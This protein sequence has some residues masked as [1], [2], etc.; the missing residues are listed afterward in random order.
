MTQTMNA[1][2]QY[3]NEA[4]ISITNSIPQSL[5]NLLERRYL[6]SFNEKDWNF[7]IES[8]YSDSVYLREVKEIS[9][10]HFPEDMFK[11]VPFIHTSCH[12]PGYT[13][14]SIIN[15]DGQKN[16]IFLGGKRNREYK[17][18]RSI[19]DYMNNIYSSNKSF[20]GGLILGESFALSSEKNALLRN[21]INDSKSCAI[22]TGIPS[23]RNGVFSLNNQGLDRLCKSVS[24]K[25]T[26]MIVAKAI[27]PMEL[28]ELLDS[29]IKLKSEIHSLIIT[30]K[31]IGKS[32]SKTNGINFKDKNN[33]GPATS[34][35]LMG[36]SLF[37]QTL[38]LI[39]GFPNITDLISIAHNGGMHMLYA[40][41]GNESPT[42][43]QSETESTSESYN[44][45]ILDAHAQEV[46][47]LLN[48]YIIRLQQA[49]GIG[50]WN[51]AVYVSAENSEVLNLVIGGL[52]SICSGDKTHLDP[53]REIRLDPAHIKSAMLSGEL[54]KLEPKEFKNIQHPFGKIFNY[55]STC[56][57]S[58][59]LSILA[60]L[61]IKEIVGVPMKRF[62]KF[63]L[64]VPKNDEESI[65]IGN[66]C[67][68]FDNELS[69]IRI[70]LK[71]LNLHT[72]VAGMPGFGKTTT[73]MQIITEAYINHN[74][75][76][77]VIE[78][79][80]KEYRQLVQL[81]KLKGTLKVFSIE[82]N[83]PT[84]FRLNP[85]EFQEGV[86]ISRH[87][88]LLKAVFNASFPMFAGMT[89]VL[90]EALLAV[91][92]E[93]GWNIFTSENLYIQ[94]SDTETRYALMPT[95]ED[96]Y[97]KIEGVMVEKKYGKEIHQ[98]LEA[99]LKS[100]IKS[101]TVGTK[102][103]VLNTNRSIP[104]EDLMNSPSIIE[105]QDLGDDQEKAFVMALILINLYEYA[106]IRQD[107][108]PT[109]KREKLQHLTLIE[110]AHRLLSGKGVAV[111]DEVGDPRSK[112]VSMFTDMLAEVRAYGEGL[113]IADQ[114]PTKLAPEI[115][116]N[117]NLKIMH[118]LSAH[119]DRKLVGQALNLTESQTDYLNNLPTFYAIIHDSNINEAVLSKVFSFKERKLLQ[120]TSEQEVQLLWEVAQGNDTTYL[121]RH[122]GCDKCQ[123]PC[124]FYHFQ[125][126]AKSL[127]QIQN[128]CKDVFDKLMLNKYEECIEMWEIHS[129]NFFLEMQKIRE[130]SDSQ[131]KGILFCLVVHIIRGYQETSLSNLHNNKIPIIKVKL[132]KKMSL[133]SEFFFALIYDQSKFNKELFTEVRDKINNI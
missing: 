16:K 92:Q 15:N 75:P 28:D 35:I 18:N 108:M 123:M 97:H 121:K 50:A 113:I 130:W 42:K 106:E 5:I 99:A 73:C 46:E 62:S 51:T 133:I 76:F 91:Y 26:L 63:A 128:N 24:G 29:C 87:I 38:K 32:S 19:S 60:H 77:L 105:L 12:D 54:I 56:L 93:R 14:L 126:T 40:N 100:R 131:M 64:S 52:K 129:K 3:S 117:T 107:K 83:S 132:S 21:K 9:L 125:E 124:Q 44:I 81:N 59:E 102:G 127:I 13:Y 70:P 39:S 20:N 114:I 110:E 10:E 120:R 49:K 85:L 22:L 27:D 8:T 58:E 25:F 122:N 47:S 43:N 4:L 7:S 94:S 23:G 80:K 48:K 34:S 112:A 1:L 55:L 84:P 86:S 2:N 71:S 101:L 90:E 88:D 116:K 57:S 17:T 66:L 103:L 98:N 61:P 69:E 36:A 115:V 74:I 78:P 31:S 68:G 95:L 67:D 33:N 82:I 53:I 6:T 45:E 118:R 119:D 111:N 79:A 96:L 11:A 30:T 109:S 72:M 37:L 41:R 104:I 65:M 89:Y